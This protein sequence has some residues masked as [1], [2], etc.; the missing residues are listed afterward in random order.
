MNFKRSGMRL[1][2]LVTVLAMA[3]AIIPGISFAAGISPELQAAVDALVIHN[4]DDIRGSITLPSVG[5][6]GAAITWTSSDEAVVS[7]E[8]IENE[9][10]L[11]A[12]AGVVTRGAEDTKVTLTATVTLNGESAVKTFDLNVKAAPSGE[13]SLMDVDNSDSGAYL[14]FYF[15]DNGKAQQQIYI[16]P[17]VRTVLHG[18]S[19]M[20]DILCCCPLWATEPY[21]ILT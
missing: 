16:L 15:T 1:L 17:P 11:S 5:E 7:T 3:L 14:F 20:T 10:Y 8:E 13:V 19:S 18:R 2:A 21:A 4:A 12:P 9:G 6:N